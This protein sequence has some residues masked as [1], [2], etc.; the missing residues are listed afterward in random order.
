[1][2]NDSK[3]RILRIVRV[4]PKAGRHEELEQLLDDQVMGRL[5]DID[6]MLERHAGRPT[7]Y[8]SSDYVVTTVWRDKDALRAFMGASVSAPA[9]VGGVA[10]PAAGVAVEMYELFGSDEIELAE[11]SAD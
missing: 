1:M 3:P 9:L 4:T 11:V 5:A 8:G 2:R 10:G 7:E 6:G